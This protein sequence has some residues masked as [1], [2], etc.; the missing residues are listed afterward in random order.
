M[1]KLIGLLAIAL[2][3][4]VVS[5]ATAA[6]LNTRPVPVGSNSSEPTLNTI[7]NGGF[8]FFNWGVNVN[9]D[10]V[11]YAYFQ[12]SIDGATGD[13]SFTLAFVYTGLSRTDA[14]GIYALGNTGD[15]IE[16]FPGGSSTNAPA[17]TKQ[18]VWGYDFANSEWDVYLDDTLEAD[19]FGLAFGY[20]LRRGDV[21]TPYFFYSEDDLNQDSAAQMIIFQ[22]PGTTNEWAVCVEDLLNNGQRDP[23]YPGTCDFDFQDLVVKVSEANPVVPEPCTLLLVGGGL[24]GLAGFRRKFKK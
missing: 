22:K 10:Q 21:Q 14:F 12:P 1:K 11:P 16:I 24:L 23:Y 8:P 2:M 6:L 15:K 9:T 19:G 5:T 7:L 20:Y 18:L 3:L 17:N 13:T 4:C